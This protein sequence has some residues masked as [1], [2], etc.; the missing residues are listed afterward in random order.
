ML[1]KSENLILKKLKSF[2][3]IQ[4]KPVEN[5]WSLS[6]AE[7][8]KMLGSDDRGISDQEAINLL[9]EQNQKRLTRKAWHKDLLLLLSQYKNPLILLLVF[10]ALLSLALGEYSDSSIVITILLLTGIFGFIQERNAGRAVEKLQAMV[11]SKTTVKRAGIVKEIN[12]EEVVPGD[13]IL[14]SAGN[15][16]PADAL[17]LEAN[18]LHV[19]EAVL[20]GESYPAEKFTGICNVESSLAQSTNAVFKGTNVING[21]GIVLAVN[22]GQYTEMGKISLRLEKSAPET[23]FEKGIRQFG[24]LLMRITVII[25]LLILTLNILLHKPVVDSLLFAL[26][27]AVGLAPELLPAVVTITLSVGARRM[28]AKKVIVKKLSA[29][30]NLGEMDILCS[31]KTGTLTQGVVKVQATVGTTGENSEK[32][33]QYVY[34]NASFET[35][36]SN[37]I[38]EA[39][40]GLENIDLGNCVKKDEVPYD[41]IRKRLS[42]VTDDSNGHIM[43][44]KGAVDNILQCCTQAELPDGKIVEMESV[45][46]AIQRLF[47]QYSEQGFRTIGVCYKDVGNDPVINKDDETGMIFLGF[48]TFFDPPKEQI[49]ESIKQLKLAGVSLKL[50]TGDNKLVARHVAAQIGLTKD[51]ILTGFDLHHLTADALQRKVE[52]VDVFAEIEPS[53]KEQIIRSLQKNGH[54]VGYV[55]DGINDANAL[56]IADIG[57]SVDNAVDVAKEAAALVLLEKNIDVI[58]EGVLEGRKTFTNTLKYIFVTTSANF[59]N[60]FSMAIASLFLPFLPLLPAQILL[61]NFLS[62]FPALAIASDKVDEEFMKKPRRWDMKYIKRFMIIFGLQSSVFDFLTFGLLL[63]VFHAAPDEF[64]TGWFMESLLTEIL[65]LLV[66]RT[67]RPFFKSKPSKYLLAACFFTFCVSVILPYLPFS[68]VFELYALPF[69]LLMGILVI[70]VAYIIASEITKKFLMKKV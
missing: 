36:F 12:I 17:L 41:F 52:T 50:I 49:I 70:A 58:L 1:K 15:I 55:G 10:A 59:G 66:I 26:A 14:L 18:D 47:L 13:I 67:Q 60:M 16:I 35:G 63:Y 43:I 46:A 37:P 24:Y 32:V 5:F 62:D 27:L 33:R 38:D 40:R 64:R 11:L 65:I 44:T 48:V 28:A 42:V 8:F 6:K 4:L 34:R 39:I 31:D 54:A 29:I 69:K 45:K 25:S 20:T 61:N 56:K 51:E 2:K 57:I 53:Q 7:L 30:Q 23:A 3:T 21:K 22:T 19:N 9:R 68:K